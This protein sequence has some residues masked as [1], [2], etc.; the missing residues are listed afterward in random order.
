M[1]T[2]AETKT[3]VA[4]DL[5][6]SDLTD[7]TLGQHVLAAIQYIEQMRDWWWLEKVVET[8]LTQ[9]DP[10]TLPTDFYAPIGWA[11]KLD[12]TYYDPLALKDYS[13]ILTRWDGSTTGPPQ[14]Y[15]IIGREAFFGPSP[16]Q[17]Y[18][19]RLVYKSRTLTNLGDAEYTYSTEYMALCVAARACETI[20]RSRLQDAEEADRHAQNFER[21]I[22]PHE[23]EDDRR[24]YDRD[25][26]NVQP[27]R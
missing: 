14:E 4:S 5:W 11:L 17:T 12:T 18:I 6:A 21:F 7:A 26:G 19:H 23:D 20:A 2:F 24:K 1:G 3:L 22:A 27:T 8:P 13:D 16:D 9:A 25:S 10:M 15:A